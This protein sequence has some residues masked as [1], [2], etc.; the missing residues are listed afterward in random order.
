MYKNKWHAFQSVD[1]INYTDITNETVIIHISPQKTNTKKTIINDAITKINNTI[2]VMDN[3]MQK[4]KKELM[5]TDTGKNLLNNI[6]LALPNTPRKSISDKLNIIIESEKQIN[7]LKEQKERLSGTND[8]YTGIG[9]ITKKSFVLTPIMAT[10][11]NQTK[12]SIFS[13]ESHD[14]FSI[15]TEPIIETKSSPD[16]LK[17]AN[18]MFDGK[19][20]F[21]LRPYG[22]QTILNE[23]TENIQTYS[24]Q[25]L[26]TETSKPIP[27]I[28]CMM[29]VKLT[30]DIPEDI[31]NRLDV[32]N[33]N[34]KTNNKSMSD[35]KLVGGKG[36]NV[37]KD[38]I[39]ISVNRI[40]V[41]LNNAKVRFNKV[42][43]YHQF[44]KNLHK[45]PKEL[46]KELCIK[47]GL[48]SS[49]K[50]AELIKSIRRIIN[51]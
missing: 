5:R 35:I 28:S 6:N 37:S 4:T 51:K 12:S 24:F 17:S 3:K 45:I 31:R 8:S 26:N 9:I 32:L 23:P 46:L 13:K 29:Y 20:D 2:Q 16:I 43:M 36:R 1:S 30:K 22:L 38:I 27:N 40:K 44:A 14:L 10:V 19:T 25:L 15:S 41:A 50:K 48:D 49:G 7:D 34:I 39:K 47:N 18:L 42:D 21:T 11:K 33:V